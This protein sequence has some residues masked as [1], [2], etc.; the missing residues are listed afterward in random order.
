MNHIRMA[1][2]KRLQFRTLQ[3]FDGKNILTWIEKYLPYLL[4]T[5][6]FTRPTGF[7]SAFWGANKHDIL[8]R[9]ER[10]DPSAKHELLGKNF[11]G[12][13]L[14][15]R[16]FEGVT[17]MGSSFVRSDLTGSNFMGTALMGADFSSACLVGVNMIQASC[18]GAYFNGADMRGIILRDASLMDSQLRNVTC[19]DADLRGA[20]FMAAKLEGADLKR[21][22]LEGAFFNGAML[23][24]SDL[25]GARVRNTYFT[26]A[27]LE[28]ADLRGIE[29]D[30]NTLKTICR[31]YNWRKARFD[32]KVEAIIQ[33]MSTTLDQ[34]QGTY[35]SSSEAVELEV[36]C[37]TCGVWF[38]SGIAMSKQSFETC[39]LG[40]NI[41]QCPNGH[42]HA[43]YKEDYR[44]KTVR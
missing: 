5:K 19:T 10:G 24:G 20:A 44:S 7:P 22:N 35:E 34:S 8:D 37:K 3:F 15:K 13:K 25:R 43:Y 28:E 2:E 31:S 32:P 26:K 16:V 42:R 40:G 33:L 38:G 9:L 6:F 30:E 36:Q 23:N 41:H 29:F 14:E 4:L 39:V 18:M 12:E 17:M 1:I 11:V 27:D 21:S